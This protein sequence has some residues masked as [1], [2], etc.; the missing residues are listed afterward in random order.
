MAGQL[1]WGSAQFGER[2]LRS[3]LWVIMADGDFAWVV[4][5][6]RSARGPQTATVLALIAQGHDPL[7]ALRYIIPSH[8]TTGTIAPFGVVL[9]VNVTLNA[10][11]EAR[12]R[13][14]ST[15]LSCEV[16]VMSPEM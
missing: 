5:S 3:E 6:C 16:Q 13:C 2:T 7:S 8:N 9:L 4:D 12:V 1:C 15:A 11:G 10:N 14:S